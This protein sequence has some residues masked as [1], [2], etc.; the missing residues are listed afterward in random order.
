MPSRVSL[1]GLGMGPAE[2]GWLR[3]LSILARITV[4][5]VQ[6]CS[7]NGSLDPSRVAIVLGSA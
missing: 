6:F 7:T 4:Q 3:Q 5:S 1:T 2:S